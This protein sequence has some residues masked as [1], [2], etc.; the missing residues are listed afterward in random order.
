MNIHFI[1]M[2]YNMQIILR[3]LL[4]I[5]AYSLSL[6]VLDHYHLLWWIHFD[7]MASSWQDIIKIYALL[8]FVFWVCFSIIKNII[9]ILALPLKFITLW[10]IGFVI[11][12]VIFYLCQI[13]IN[14]YLTGIEMQITS[15]TWLVIVSFILSVIVS[16]VYRLLKKVI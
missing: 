15:L 9:N 14:T 10:L 3:S 2:L 13:L 8:G 12:I 16:F 7:F 11:N 6:Y 5:I 4:H 1:L